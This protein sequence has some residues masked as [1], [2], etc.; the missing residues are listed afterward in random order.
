MP[1]PTNDT[2][3]KTT[4]TPNI[5][6]SRRCAASLVRSLSLLSISLQTQTE[7]IPPK[8]KR[9]ADT[10]ANKIQILA[11]SKRNTAGTHHLLLLIALLALH[12]GLFL[13]HHVGH[14]GCF[15]LLLLGFGFGNK[16]IG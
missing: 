1:I 6:K 4:E 15:A 10:N 13:H 14:L 2:K 12:L 9:T 16:S 3:K 7:P 11:N 8:A 5:A